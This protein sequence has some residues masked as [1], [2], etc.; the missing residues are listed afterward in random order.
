M[1]TTGTIIRELR[2]EKGISQEELSAVL[3]VTAQAVSKWEN[4]IGLPDISLLVPIADYFDVSLDYLFLRADFD[5]HNEIE[6]QLNNIE[7]L[8]NTRDKT[9][10]L[11]LLIKKHPNELKLLDSF[12]YAANSLSVEPYADKNDTVFIFAIEAADRFI[13][14]CKE[15]AKINFIKI[16]KIK[17]LC[18]VGRYDEAKELAMDFKAPIVSEHTYL[19]DICK[20]TGES[21]TEIKHR[22]ESISRMLGYLADE[23]DKLGYAYM[24]NNEYQKAAAVYERL[25]SLPTVTHKDSRF[26]APLQN[27]YSIS[28]FHLGECYIKLKRYDDAIELL[29]QIFDQALIQCECMTSC[30]RITSPLLCDIDM[31]PYHGDVVFEDMIA[32]LMYPDFLPLYDYPRFQNLLKRYDQSNTSITS[33]DKAKEMY[34]R[35]P[36]NL[37]YLLYL[38]DHEYQLAFDEDMNNGSAEYLNDMA[39]SAL[40]HYETIINE[41]KDGEL[42]KSAA[43]GKVLTLRFLERTEEADWSA[44]FEYPDSRITSAEQL[45][46]LT[47]RGRILAEYLKSENQNS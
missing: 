37:K 13:S 28:G 8:E 22:Q 17:L 21:Q 35:Y 40:A 39:D 29:E 34:C 11:A 38:A 23:I 14:L 27:F 12:V 1:K 43:I 9:A 42:T 18:F 2:K 25:L 32:P 31:S 6:D 26:H 5:P 4:D 46:Q 44:E 3:G 47:E 45:M 41:S 20:F 30:E 15:S 7:V 10:A 36:A 24:R 19:A 16:Q 33:Y